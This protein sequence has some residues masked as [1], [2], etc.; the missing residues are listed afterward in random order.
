MINI[1]FLG[2]P[3]IAE[4]GRAWRVLNHD[5]QPCVGDSDH[6]YFLLAPNL[7]AISV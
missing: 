1:S 6:R 3:T 7:L 4:G 5:F 2:V